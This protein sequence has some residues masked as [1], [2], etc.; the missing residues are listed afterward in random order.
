[1]KSPSLGQ[2]GE[3]GWIARARSKFGGASGPLTEGIGDDAAI[4]DPTPG[5]EL[6][7]TTDMILEGKHFRLRDATP[8]QIGRKALAV[9]L[10]D[11][12]AM[13]AVPRYA[14]VALGAPGGLDLRFMQRLAS[15]MNDLARRYG[16][17]I[18]GGDTNASDRLVVSVA[19]I[20]EAPKGRSVRRSGA[21]KGD[22]IFVTGKL[23]GSYRSGRHF[24]FTPRVKEALFL[25]EHF[26]LHAMMDLSDGLASDLHRLCEA[27]RVGARLQ[28]AA[29]P[30]SRAA[31]GLTAALTEGEDF[32]L[33]FTLSPKDATRLARHPKNRGRFFRPVGTIVGKSEGVRLFEKDGSSAPLPAAGF[34][35][36]KK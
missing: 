10:S 18:V 35:H 26:G 31:T 28:A 36:F 20:G 9:N 30:V 29:V 8:Y 2:I 15:G 17:R 11:A 3:F 4:F 24:T 5:C 13:A 1:M 19:L 16:V 7:F 6:I 12:A 33:L 32:E 14:V 21:K 23:G 34:D 27:S 25:A 22:V